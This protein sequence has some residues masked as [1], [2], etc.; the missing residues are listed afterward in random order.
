MGQ[1]T[2][3]FVEAEQ[4]SPFHPDKKLTDEDAPEEMMECM[5]SLDSIQAAIR[6]RDDLSACG[7]DRISYTIMKAANQREPSS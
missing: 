5:L 4:G 2:Q 6:S 3:A 1:P 7:N